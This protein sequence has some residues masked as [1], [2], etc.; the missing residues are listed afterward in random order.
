MI[1]GPSVA[2][3]GGEL[4]SLLSSLR[5]NCGQELRQPFLIPCPSSHR[6]AG[7][8]YILWLLCGRAETH[9]VVRFSLL[10]GFACVHESD[11]RTSVSSCLL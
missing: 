3:A 6:E 1:Q 8:S 4:H 9:S 7:V 11:L 5:L 2:L 10:E